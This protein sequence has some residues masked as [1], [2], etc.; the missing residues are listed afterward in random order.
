M[1]PTT[2]IWCHC[3]VY[4]PSLDMD[5]LRTVC[6]L[7]IFFYVEYVMKIPCS[8]FPVSRISGFISRALEMSNGVG[9]WL[10]FLLLVSVKVL[11]SLNL[12]WTEG[13]STNIRKISYVFPLFFESLPN[14]YDG[15][16]SMNSF[17]C[18][19][20]SYL[21]CMYSFTGEW[22]QTD[23][24]ILLLHYSWDRYDCW[25]LRDQIDEEI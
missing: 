24:G 19:R 3:V 12:G 23:T 17:Q 14:R 2:S 10:H 5:P 4:S 1:S 15:Y 20:N 9:G 8:K 6:S 13:G 18:W 22:I 7:Q 21:I 25:D 11:L 16:L